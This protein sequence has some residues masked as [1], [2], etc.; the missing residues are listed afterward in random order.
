MEIIFR[1]KFFSPMIYKVLKRPYIYIYRAL[2]IEITGAYDD[3]SCRRR[4][5]SQNL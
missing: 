5:V 4:F 1:L 2:F 3:A